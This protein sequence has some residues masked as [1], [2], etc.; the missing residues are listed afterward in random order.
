MTIVHRQN[1]FPLQMAVEIQP[2][3][4]REYAVWGNPL[5]LIAREH[6]FPCRAAS[7]KIWV[8]PPLPVGDSDPP[9]TLRCPSSNVRLGYRLNFGVHPLFRFLDRN[10]PGTLIQFYKPPATLASVTDGLSNTC[11][12]AERMSDMGGKRF[13]SAVASSNSAK[14]PDDMRPY[15]N[16]AYQHGQVAT[17]SA[18][19]W[20]THFHPFGYDHSQPPNS[21]EVDCTVY[22]RNPWPTFFFEIASRS[23]H[24]GGVS[25]GLLDGSVRWVDN[26]IDASIWK[27]LGTMAGND[28][29]GPF[30]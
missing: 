15:C 8:S 19:W 5:V 7:R 6:S 13:P 22:Q 10:E 4:P 21:R 24:S 12:M 23:E 20:S 9:P 27:A 18:E 30:D 17:D 25:C 16:T 14:T 11:M 2:D 26:G 28:A 29:A 1:Q 3:N